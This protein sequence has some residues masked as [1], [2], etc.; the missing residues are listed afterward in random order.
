MF[1]LTRH[2]NLDVFDIFCLIELR[3]K[4]KENAILIAGMSDLREYRQTACGELSRRF[5]LNLKDVSREFIGCIRVQQG[6]QRRAVLLAGITKRYGGP[7]KYPR[8]P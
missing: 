1:D 5:Y 3:R 8:G 2:Y 6:I 4:T 7:M